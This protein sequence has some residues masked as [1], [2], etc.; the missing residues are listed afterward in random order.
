MTLSKLSDDFCELHNNFASR[1]FSASSTRDNFRDLF[2]HIY[3]C[4]W[5]NKGHSDLRQMFRNETFITDRRLGHQ[6]LIL[7]DSLAGAKLEEGY[8]IS[9]CRNQL[10]ELFKDL[11]RYISVRLL[12]VLLILF[13]EHVFEDIEQIVYALSVQ[14]R[15]FLLVCIQMILWDA[16]GHFWLQ[17]VPSHI[18]YC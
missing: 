12:S 14:L 18:D 8:F 6:T 1:L 9:A 10:G 7:V 11:R 4:T 2:W 17:W 13:K 5:A 15:I 3:F 16:L